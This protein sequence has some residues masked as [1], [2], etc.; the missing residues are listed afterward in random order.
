VKRI[1]GATGY[2]GGRLAPRL[3]EADYSLGCLVRSPRQLEGRDWTSDPRV[4]VWPSDLDDHTAL[5]RDLLRRRLL[6]RPFD[7]VERPGA[8]ARS[9]HG[10]A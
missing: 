1:R 10:C 5:T 9:R 4:E 3:L 6:S 7:D 2:F 8:V